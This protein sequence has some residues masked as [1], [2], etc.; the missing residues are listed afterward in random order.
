[1]ITLTGARKVCAM[2]IR[3]SFQNTIGAVMAWLHLGSILTLSISLLACQAVAAQQHSSKSPAN[4]QQV[5]ALVQEGRLDEARTQMLDELQRNPASVDGYNLLGIIDSDLQDYPDALAA[6]QKALQLA[7]ASTRTHNNLGNAYIAQKRM[8]LAEREFR[9]VLR[10]DPANRDG[11]YNLGV[12]LLA[13]GSPAAAIPYFERVR[14]ANLPTRFNII[15]AYLQSKR[16]AEALRMAAAVSAQNKNDVQVHFSLGVLLASEKQYKAAQLELEKADALQPGTFEIVYNLGEDLIRN[17]E[18]SQAKLELTRA[19]KLKPESPETLYLL[20]QAYTNES[21]PLDALDLL[22]RAHKLA[23]DNVDTVFLMAQIGI[24]RHYYEDAIPL[25]E[26]GLQIAP[27]R[28]DLRAALGESYYMSGKVD[29]AIEEFKRLIDA[30]PSARSYLFLGLSYTHLGRFDEAKQSFQN[31]LK[32]D[33]RNSACLFNLGYIAERQGD[34]A[35]AAAI[36]QKVLLSNPNFPDALLELAKLRLESKRFAE[37]E[38]LLRRYVRVSSSPATG[39]YQLAMAERSLHQTAAADRDLQLFQ[40]L[41]KNVTVSSNPY[42]HVFEYLDSRSKLDPG[43]RDQQDL[44]GLIDEAGK[45]PDQ[46]EVQYLLAEAYLKAGK[47]D[48]ARSTIAQLD[49]ITSGGYRMQA[50]VGVLLASYHLYDD[51]IQHFQAALKM[52][53]GSDEIKFDLANAYFRKRLYSDALDIAGQVSEGGRKD[54]AYLALLGDIY[55]HQGDTA[56]AEEILRSAIIRNPDNDQEYL[57]L[58]LLQFRAGNIA[59]AKQTLLKGQ[60]RIPGSGKIIWGLG[61]ASAL[62][63]NTA[64][65]AEQFERAVEMLPEWPGA[66]STLGVFYFQTG[67]IAKAREVLDRFKNS[68]A[69]GLDIERIEQVLA[70]AP[71]TASAGNEPMPMANRKQLLQLAVALADR[72]L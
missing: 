37:A 58:A 21:R 65:A 1:M 17:G 62:E 61:L 59:D 50:G 7:P 33:P 55:A 16:A 29:Q 32:F 69:G 57:S 42:E 22:I 10:L 14:P 34:S 8:D 39:Y 31:G 40:T 64:K 35:G 2:D 72:T 49:T 20:A 12:L 19:L 27:Q 51:A 6:L 70:Q 60:A 56:R 63:G 41:S 52:N 36:F 23:P 4:F 5:E 24:S 26:S 25:L 9:T 66:Y 43:V 47:V 18:Y 68:N 15:R 13:K 3:A 28:F 30:E 71:E 11:N 45:H 38:E 48:E 67:Q 44:A 54:D 53:P 46:P